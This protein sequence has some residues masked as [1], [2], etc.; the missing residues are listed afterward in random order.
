VKLRRKV[1]EANSSKSFRTFEQAMAYY[2]A[3]SAKPPTKLSCHATGIQYSNERMMKNLVNAKDKYEAAIAMQPEANPRYRPRPG[4]TKSKPLSSSFVGGTALRARVEV[5]HDGHTQ[6][7]A[8]DC[9]LDSMSD[10]TMATVDLLHD[11]HDI[12]PEDVS[13]S[14][15]SARFSRE[16]TLKL[17]VNGK[18]VS[19]PSLVAEEGHL[20]HQCGVLLGVPGLDALGVQLDGHRKAQRLPLICHVGEKILRSWLETRSSSSIDEIDFDVESIDVNPELSPGTI[21]RVRLLLKR[22]E[23]V[24]E[25]KQNTL[26]KPFASEPVELKFVDDPVPQSVPEPKWTFAQ[27][28]IITQWAEAGLKDGSLELSTSQWASRPHIVM[29]TPAKSHKDHT[30]LSK[31]KLRICGDYRRAN[32]QIRKI[33]PNLPSGLDEVERAAGHRYYWESDSVACYSQFVLAPGLSRQALAIWSPIGLVQPTTLP[34]GQKNSGTEAQGPYRAAAAELKGGRH[35]NYVDDWI[36]W[37]ESEEQLCDDFAQFLAVCEKYTITLGTT[38]TRFGYPTAQ[39]FGFCVDK[40]GSC[41]ATKHLDPLAK[42]VPPADIHELRRVLGL[43]V[44]SRKYVKDFAVKTKPLTDILKGKP[45]TFFW[46]SAQQEAFDFIREKLL[47]G[48]HLAAPDF[49][50]PFHLATDASEDGNAVPGTVLPP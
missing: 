28:Q 9:G 40:E 35:G 15:S 49:T 16:G 19:V 39:F 18:V 8:V 25:G 33:V 22:Y 26:P 45:P 46:A 21:A 14:G 38:K 23:G 42:L 47:S 30:D 24:F 37:S 41:L 10:V 5:W 43:F 27:K 20:P 4:T 12:L 3:G 2:R 31:C 50:L 48:I 1:F 32:S 44:V 29:K 11:V 17:L 6:T 36:G 34:F 13:T 7:T